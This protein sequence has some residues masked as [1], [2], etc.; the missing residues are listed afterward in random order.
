MT[1]TERQRPT[2][3]GGTRPAPP[4]ASPACHARWE[5]FDLHAGVRIPAG[6]RDRL[7]QVCRYALRPPMA[8]DH[9]RLTAAGD[10]ALQLRRPWDDG[11]T[12]LVFAPVAFLARLAVLLPRPRINL[13]LYHGVLAPRAAWR[14]AVGRDHI[15]SLNAAPLSDAALPRVK[16]RTSV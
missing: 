7:E 12:H 4:P 16:S 10:V 9:L 1:G 14:A 13:V 3:L 5:G 2:R 8:G 15:L 11:T 6:Q